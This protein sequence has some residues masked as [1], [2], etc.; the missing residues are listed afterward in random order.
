VRAHSLRSPICTD[1]PSPAESRRCGRSPRKSRPDVFNHGSQLDDTYACTLIFPSL[2]D[3]PALVDSLRNTYDIV[4]VR[5]RA[6]AAKDPACLPL[7]RNSRDSQTSRLGPVESSP[8]ASGRVA[9]EVQLR[10]AFEHAW[11]VT[12]RSVSYS[13][14]RID[15]PPPKARGPALGRQLNNSTS[16]VA[17]YDALAEHL[18]PQQWPEIATKGADRGG[19]Q[20]RDRGRKHPSELAPRAGL[21]LRQCLRIAARRGDRTQGKGDG[22]SLQVDRN[23]ATRNSEMDHASFPRSVSSSS[24]S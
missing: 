22:R 11:C 9:F 17:G 7:R 13:S 6:P 10:T 21:A 8:T 2:Q 5:R 24:L 23:P 12:T 19:I 1:T 18:A 15:W 4:E 20:G 14:D 3:E 16:L